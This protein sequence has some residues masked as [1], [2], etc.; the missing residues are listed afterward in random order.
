M[1]LTRVRYVFQGKPPVLFTVAGVLIAGNF[2]ALMVLGA[3][4]RFWA[5]GQA[6]AVF[7]WYVE[8]GLTLHFVLLGAGFLIAFL[9]RK[10]MVRVPVPSVGDRPASLVDVVV[11][12]TM[13]PAACGFVGSLVAGAIYSQ[14]DRTWGVGIAALAVVAAVW[15]TDRL[16]FSFPQST[17]FRKRRPAIW[18][19]A[20]TVST[21]VLTFIVSD[22]SR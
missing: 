14:V 11:A 3:T 13:A 16:I 22:F 21:V 20:A 9:Y 10:Q 4:R 19:W 7:S 12:A 6:S 15:T 18:L 8:Q 2:V 1:P 5:G 17:P